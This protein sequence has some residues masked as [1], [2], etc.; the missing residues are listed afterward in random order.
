M[1]ARAGVPM[2]LRSPVK[3]GRRTSL[4]GGNRG[5][6]QYSV[7]P[8]QDYGDWMRNR[9]AGTRNGAPPLHA[10]QVQIDETMGEKQDT[11]V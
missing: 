5:E 6:Y 4:G 8:L 7:R 2:T 9:E 3:G 10:H 11:A 1:P